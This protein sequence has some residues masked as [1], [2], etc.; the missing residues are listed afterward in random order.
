MLIEIDSKEEKELIKQLEKRTDNEAKRML[1]F[2]RMPDLT[3]TTGSPLAELVKRVKQIPALKDFDDIKIPEIVPTRVLFD[4]F[5]MPPGHPSRSKSDTYYVDQDHILITHDTVMWHYYFEHPQVKEKIAR[6]EDLGV[7]CYTKVYRKDEIDRRHMNVFHQFGGLYLTRDEKRKVTLD[8]LKQVLGQVAQS[9]FGPKVEYNF[10]PETFPYTDPSCEMNIKVRGEWVEMVGSGLPRKDVLK[11]F[12]ITGY[13]G[14][15][16]GFGLERLAMVSMDLPDIRLLWSD[17]PRVRSQLKLGQK[18]KE[19]SKYPSVTRDISF[20]V[21]KGFVPND[22]FDLIRDL[23]GDLV[24][25]VELLDKY[26]DEEKFG[27]NKMSYTYRIVYRSMERTLVS[28]EVDEI[29]D[30][31]Y[32]ETAKQFSAELR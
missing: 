3:R 22:Y 8:D 12:D 23:G 5:N 6:G 11:N 30:K 31:I 7:V 10:T 1:R 16:F 13:N 4:L 9:I 20:V 26:E 18:F 15:A 19:I 2:L 17:D 25:Q 21:D 24:E 27:K 14:W 32:K 28:K 29:Q